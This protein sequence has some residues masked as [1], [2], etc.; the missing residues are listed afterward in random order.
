LLVY[1]QRRQSMAKGFSLEIDP[2]VYR[3]KHQEDGTWVEEYIEKPHRSP[4]EEAA[5]PAE[6]KAELLLERNN[7]S[8]LPVVNY[9][10][11]YGMGCFEGLKAF[12]QPDGTL[13]LFRP[14]EN[15]KRMASSMTGLMMP[16][17]PEAK[18]VAAVRTIVIKNQALGFAP[19]YDPAWAAGDFVQGSA[20]YIR[21]F[22]YAEPGIGVGVSKA[23]WVIGV[24]PTRAVPAGSRLTRTT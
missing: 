22:T 6:K 21:P 16:P 10:T 17:F 13:S 12:P 7:F 4:R 19:V 8:D 9:T 23:P 1:W 5:L 24:A 11:Q 14:D 18:F 2:W 20:V 15:A 3:A